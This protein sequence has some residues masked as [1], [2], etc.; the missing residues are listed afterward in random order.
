MSPKKMSVISFFILLICFVAMIYLSNQVYKNLTETY[1][2]DKQEYVKFVGDKIVVDKD[3][4][5]V[6]DYSV[7]L[8]KFY[9]SNGKDVSKE[10]VAKK[11]IRRSTTKEN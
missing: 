1:E 2:L 4:L 6:T 5:E 10:Y 7:I 11:S 9:L 3:T 8:K